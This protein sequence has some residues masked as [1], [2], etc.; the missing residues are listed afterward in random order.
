MAYVL[1]I[2]QLSMGCRCLLIPIQMLNYVF[3]FAQLD[4]ILEIKQMTGLASPPAL[5]LLIDLLTM[6]P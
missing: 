1:H 4:I 5:V 2:V 6:S 3:T